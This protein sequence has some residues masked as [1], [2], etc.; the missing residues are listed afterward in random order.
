MQFQQHI[1]LVGEQE[2]FLPL[3]Y[4][5]ITEIYYLKI[6]II[7]IQINLEYLN[8]PIYLDNCTLVYN[9]YCKIISYHHQVSFW[10]LL[11]YS[12]YFTF[13]VA[14]NQ[15]TATHHFSYRQYYYLA[16]SSSH[17]KHYPISES[18]ITSRLQTQYC[19]RHGSEWCEQG[20]QLHSQVCS[21]LPSAWQE[22]LIIQPFYGLRNP[23]GFKIW[24][25][26]GIVSP[27]PHAI[28]EPQFVANYIT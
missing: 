8:N 13:R 21:Q 12:T 25:P 4:Q 11:T 9:P 3:V 1:K 7:L 26:P 18:C 22:R 28:G 10:C 2:S 15:L 19:H 23:Y 17:K 5:E 16:V 27:K 24:E 6:Q 14:L 20:S